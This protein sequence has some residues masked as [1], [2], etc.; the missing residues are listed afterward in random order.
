MFFRKLDTHLEV[1]R[2]HIPKPGSLKGFTFLTPTVIC[3]TVMGEKLS[4]NLT[5]WKPILLGHSFMYG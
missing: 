5:S 3:L 4:R 2:R 1:T